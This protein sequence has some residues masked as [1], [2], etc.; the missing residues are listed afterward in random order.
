[1]KGYFITIEGS[2]GSGK[3]TQLK[4]IISYLE[5]KQVDLVVTREPGGTDV[6]EAIRELILDPAYPQ[7]TAK[8]EMLLYAAARAQHVEEKLP[9]LQAGKVVLSDRYVDSSI[10][11]QAYGRGLGDMVAQVNAIA[12]GG[13]VPDL[14]VFLDLPPAVGMAR[15]QQEENHE[16]DR[17][18]QEKLEFHQKVYEGYDALCKKE[19]ERIC[20]IDASGTIEEVFGQIKAALDELLDRA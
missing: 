13:L 12:T 20:R 18:E 8:T 3:S 11:Y 9:G 4:K 1:M 6:A 5:E 7:M 16:L 17:L 10:A 15:K 19:L 14:T 2:D